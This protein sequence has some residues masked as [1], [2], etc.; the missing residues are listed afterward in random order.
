MTES[1]DIE[2]KANLYAGARLRALRGQEA[3]VAFGAR[4]GMKENQLFK[5]ERGLTRLSIG[6]MALLSSLLDVPLS[7]FIIPD[8]D[9]VF[10]EAAADETTREEEPTIQT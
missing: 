1:N 3:R 9:P 4:I 10:G 5:F 7:Y 8:D 2:T 6:K